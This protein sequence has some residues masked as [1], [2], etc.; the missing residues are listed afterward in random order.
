MW[1]RSYLRG[2]VV[3]H[4]A[5]RPAGQ[6]P[7]R[8]PRRRRHGDHP[9]TARP[10]GGVPRPRLAAA[11]AGRPDP[12]VQ[13]APGREEERRGPA[14]HRRGARRPDPAGRHDHGDPGRVRHRDRGRAGL[15]GRRRA[16]HAGQR[17]RTRPGRRGQRRPRPA[18]GGAR[19]AGA[20][21]GALSRPR[22]GEGDDVGARRG[23]RHYGVP[24]DRA[25]PAYA[26]L[27][28][29]R[30]DPSD[31][32]PGVPG[33]G[34]KTAATLL[35]QHGSLEGILAAAHDPKSKMSKAYRTKLLA[36]TD[37]IE[38]AGPVV[39]WPPT[40]TSTSRRRRTCCRWPPSIRARSPNSPNNTA[41]RRRSADCRRRLTHYLATSF[42]C[43]VFPQRSVSV[44][45]TALVLVGGSAAQS[46]PPAA[47]VGCSGS[48]RPAGLLAKVPEFLVRTID[49]A[50][51]VPD[52]RGR[53]S[54]SIYATP[55]LPSTAP[56]IRRLATITSSLSRSLQA[57]RS[58]AMAM[59]SSTRSC[60]GWAP[61]P[62]P[63]RS[64]WR[65]ASCSL[66]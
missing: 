33:V 35:A 29:L 4:R 59:H 19:R 46:S 2:A 11:V 1:F 48:N 40:P 3:D 43:A 62:A 13:G 30:G 49:P 52:P 14:R 57:M 60:P 9:R 31:G 45:A 63:A 17:E 44:F 65:T 12:V 54:L 25:G 15:R 55:P 58:P 61:M 7:A 6:R 53:R 24:L 36:A 37:Y 32:L 23:R 18:A 38:A 20:G 34:E 50:A 66:S 26:E 10:A 16:G 5:R 39:G 47:A 41:S 51:R 64:P 28:L 8:L 22:P 21:P 27:A 56:R 42:A